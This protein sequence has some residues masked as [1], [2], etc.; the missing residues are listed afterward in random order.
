[1][2]YFPI[3]YYGIL[4]TGAVVVP[5]N[6]LLKPREIAYHLQDSDAKVYFC[7]EGTAELAMGQMGHAG[8]N[9]AQAAGAPVQHF[10]LMTANP[11]A[12]SPIEGV[13]TLGQSI[14]GKSPAF[15]TV[16]RSSEDTA[17]ILYTS[18]TTGKPKGAELTH[19]NMI[20]NVAQLTSDTCM[21]GERPKEVLVLPRFTTGK[22]FFKKRGEKYNNESMPFGE[23][24]D[25]HHFMRQMRPCRF[26]ESVPEGARWR[27]INVVGIS[28][29]WNYGHMLPRVYN[30]LRAGPTVAPILARSLRRV[31]EG[32]GLHWSAVH[33][34]IE[35]DWM[36]LAQFCVLQRYTP[37]RC[38]TPTEVAQIT[39]DARA[40]AKST[41][42]LLL[43]ATDLVSPAGP[44]VKP[45][46]YREPTVKLPKLANA[47]Y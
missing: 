11:A 30:A 3:V 39:Q 28:K 19:N 14:Y 31:E 20:M 2:P 1:L 37:R 29:T 5:L 10:I 24:F 8:F 12:P 21:R 42:T 26:A 16:G 45:R 13:K 40:R 22:N 25:A 6:V 23:L 41:G 46:A 34:R 9:E 47:S 33:L 44:V 7:F 38:F 17:V 18:G 43:Y 27:Y 35:S 4:K 32:A 36:F 15:D